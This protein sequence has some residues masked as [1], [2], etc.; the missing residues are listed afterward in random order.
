[1]SEAHLRL[2][3]DHPPSVPPPDPLVGRTVDGRYR[4]E[5][6]LGEGGM[7]LVYRARHAVLNKPLAIKVLRPE[8]SRDAEVMSRFQQ[9]AQSASAIGNHHIIDISDFGVL[10]D[11]STYFVMEF[12]DGVPLTKAIEETHPM[13][14]ARVI[15]IAKQLCDGLGAAHE[16]N[17][18]HRDLKPDNVYLIR[19]GNDTDF[20]KVLD[21]GIAKVGGSS[22]KLT[23]AGQVFGTPH[24]MS[25]EPCSG[26]V[27]DQR[28]D[29]YA[30]GVMLYEM[31]SG[32]VPF[33]ADNLMGILT[34]HL[35][36][37]PI[38]PREL[39]PP[40]DVPPGLEA[41]IMK[42]LAKSA[43]ARYQSMA[44][45]R[46][47]LERLESGTTPQAVVDAVDRASGGPRPDGTGRV[48]LG[49]STAIRMGE[50]NVPQPPTSKHSP[51]LIG[52]AT[53]VVLGLLVG[54][55]YLAYASTEGATAPPETVVTPP[56][57]LSPSGTGDQGAAV[58][59]A[60]AGSAGA[61]SGASESP[62]AVPGTDSPPIGAGVEAA[63]GPAAVPAVAPVR[64]ETDPP[65]AEVLV[66]NL[67]LGITPLDV[68]RPTSGQVTAVTLR[69]RGYRE[70]SLGITEVSPSL[71]QRT[72]TR[73]IGR[74]ARGD[75]SASTSASSTTGTTM[76]TTMTSETT[77]MRGGTGG[78][79]GI[80]DPWQ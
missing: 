38:P 7:G 58:G 70:E 1:M 64:I 44:E 75:T 37:Q 54:G 21:F 16:R 65:G 62:P 25:P 33:D 59:S 45:L 29:I 13:P 10:P 69:L 78:P 56:E 27:V 72:L 5:A 42:C 14:A 12:L 9:E 3:D 18:V 53:V 57:T 39:P 41:I 31:T 68:P 24:Y 79:D 22:S 74:G 26:A 8:V 2:V 17:I 47:D 76:E 60:G 19:R 6:V 28:T 32:R 43:D 77:T 61:G 50:G 40:V 80:L 73:A 55:G 46:A 66:G 35:Y 15:H 63:G 36:E 52:G 49:Q 20:V 51:V 30:L 48:A 34:K 71:M 67:V 23:K 11:G 4:I